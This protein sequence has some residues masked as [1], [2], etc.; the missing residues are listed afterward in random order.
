MIPQVREPKSP[1]I[2][3]NPL[4]VILNNLHFE[5]RCINRLDNITLSLNMDYL[6]VLPKLGR[7]PLIKIFSCIGSLNPCVGVQRCKPRKQS[8]ASL[9]DSSGNWWD[10][11]ISALSYAVLDFGKYFCKNF[12][13]T[14]SHFLRLFP[15][16]KWSHLLT[17]LAREKENR[18][19]RIAP[20]GTPTI[21]TVLHISM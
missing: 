11:E 19:R 9:S 6:D 7:K 4:I 14:S 21:L 20:S 3:P 12:S 2:P 15:L 10:E 1:N 5:Q 8:K 16:N 13:K 17:S 18:L